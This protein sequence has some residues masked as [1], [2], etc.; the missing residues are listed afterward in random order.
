MVT[1]RTKKPKKPVQIY[2]YTHWKT[3]GF[4][5]SEGEAKRMAVAHSGPKVSWRLGEPDSLFDYEKSFGI[6]WPCG[7]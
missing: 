3:I 4:A 7:F 1:K 2:A 6:P 5:C